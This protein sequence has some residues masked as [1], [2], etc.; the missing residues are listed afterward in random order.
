M[1]KLL[2]IFS[3]VITSLLY[4]AEDS[5]YVIKIKCCSW[6]KCYVVSNTT[7]D[8]LNKSMHF[9]DKKE[10]KNFIKKLSPTIR[11]MNPKIKFIEE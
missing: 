7:F 6:D 11:N 10:A 4:A 9:K 2:V 8:S 5:Y 1:K 3:F